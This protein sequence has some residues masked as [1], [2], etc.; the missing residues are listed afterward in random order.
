M[1]FSSILSA[2]AL[3]SSSLA[4]FQKATTGCGSRY[5][6]LHSENGRIQG[7][8]T[9]KGPREKRE[10]ARGGGVGEAGERNGGWKAQKN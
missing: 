5:L 1:D 4:V 7:R 2:A 3:M 10:R 6:T 8:E 9:G